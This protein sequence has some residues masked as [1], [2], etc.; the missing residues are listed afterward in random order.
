[1]VN[2]RPISALLHHIPNHFGALSEE[3]L[4]IRAVLINK[5]TD[6]LQFHEVGARVDVAVLPGIAP[7]AEHGDEFPFRELPVTVKVPEIRSDAGTDQRRGLRGER[8][9]EDDIPL[10]AH[11]AV[12]AP[13]VSCCPTVP[14][15][16]GLLNR[17]PT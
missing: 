4:H 1:M 8:R 14:S 5:R 6:A 15:L 13:R 9:A 11:R 3:R 17:I 2:G 10:K 12:L 7:V 16:S